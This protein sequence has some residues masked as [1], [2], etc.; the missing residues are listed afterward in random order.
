MA[1]RTYRQSGSDANAVRTPT[2]CLY[3]S[4]GSESATFCHSCGTMWLQ[5]ELTRVLEC[6]NQ[7]GA[8]LHV[9][10]QHHPTKSEKTYQNR[11]FGKSLKGKC[12]IFDYLFRSIQP[13]SRSDGA[14]PKTALFSK[15]NQTM[16]SF[17]KYSGNRPCDLQAVIENLP[18]GFRK[19]IEIPKTISRLLFSLTSA[20][21]FGKTRSINSVL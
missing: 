19:S 9:H 8:D 13:P 6:V 12:C 20:I 16:K 4:S 21:D 11:F 2:R 14:G 5:L 18:T 15:K 1:W 7:H 17:Q 10:P 3:V